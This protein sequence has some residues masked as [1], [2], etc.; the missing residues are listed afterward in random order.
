LRKDPLAHHGNLPKDVIHGAL[1][2]VVQVFVAK[3]FDY[4]N[5]IEKVLWA[6]AE[7]QWLCPGLFL[8]FYFFI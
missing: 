2:G 7:I 3:L 1:G 5:D 6:A 4:L 8:K